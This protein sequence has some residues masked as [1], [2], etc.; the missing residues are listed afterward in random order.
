MRLWDPRAGDNS[1]TKLVGHTECVRS[2]LLSDDGRYMLTGSSDTT[3]KLWSVGEHRC[4]HTFNHHTSSVW[5][6]HS[7]HP[8]LERFYS[9]S[10][11][12]YLCAIDVEQVGDMSE[13]ECVVLGRE[14]EGV[15]PGDFESKTGDEAI[16]SITAMDDEYVWTATASSD[17]RRWRD[18]GR[19]VTRLDTDFDGASYGAITGTADEF[20]PLHPTASVS[21][22]AAFEP[23]GIIDAP[24]PLRNK[25][26]SVHEDLRRVDSA[27][28]RTIT[29]AATSPPGSPAS[30]L[31]ASVRDRLNPNRAARTLSG[32]SVTNSVMSES[33]VQGGDEFLHNG[34]PYDSLVCLGLPD[35]PYAFGFSGA[36]HSTASLGST[37]H[38]RARS[39]GSPEES[40]QATTT[41][42]TGDRGA[43]GE[44]AP[45]VAARREFEDRDV[46]ADARPLR[47]Q[48]DAVI[49]GS[50]GLI[51]SLV[52]ND[53][54]HVLTLDT[55]GEIAIWHL[56]RGECLGRFDKRDVAEALE[57]ERGTQ[58]VA[59]EIKMHPHEVLELVQR[60][61]EGKNSV[62]PWCQVD[63]KVGQITVHLEGDRVFAAEILAEEMG[64]D[65]ATLPE[66]SKA[67]N[68]GKTVLGN[69]FRGLIKAEELE[70]TSAV[71]SSPSSVPGSLPS[72]SRSPANAMP[73]SPRHRQRALSSASL[74]G[75]IAPSI[76]IAG[77]ATRAERAAVLPEGGAGGVFGQSA[78]A[79][80]GWLSLPAAM[81]SRTPGSF[82]ASSPANGPLSPQAGGVT[83]DYFSMRK[84]PEASPTRE[85]DK[86]ATTSAPAPSPG[87]AAPGGGLLGKKK[88][89]GFG[90]KKAAESTM[91][92]VVESKREAPPPDEGPK[93]SERD[94]SQ[95]LFLD[96]VR[97]RAFR[98][99]SSAECP[100]I[101][102]P[103]STTLI[104]SEQA[105]ADGAYIVTYRSQV[106]ST[107]RDMEPLEMNS[108]FW[109]LNYLFASI[110]P[111][112]RRPPKIP[113]ILL[114][115]GT[116]VGSGVGLKVQASRTA[117][118]RGV[119]EHLQNVLARENGTPNASANTRDRA[120]SDASA[121]SG[122]SGIDDVPK[123]APEDSIELLCGQHVAEADM[124]VAT[125][126]QCYWRGGVDMVLH[127]RVKP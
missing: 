122:V 5:A 77:L 45:R 93:M 20:A 73:M 108:P 38:H 47:D 57:L 50:P 104:I 106:S 62:L 70:V 82:T 60:R 98:P 111:E 87:A 115:V 18:V 101:P 32:T 61:V 51:R 36:A 4:L 110:T 68:V 88:F 120:V 69:L 56:I 63:T 41:D 113:L 97:N 92:T 112:E 22:A 44:V 118:V 83:S 7:N 119:M 126:K 65:E 54:M 1:V 59:A 79:T 24:S 91:T 10:R 67:L 71:S 85:A 66:D 99:P 21:L 94:R 72:V 84:I 30:A 64:I 48:P 103:P 2:I 89:M 102:A 29:F 16:R 125:L 81:A 17:V 9:G 13:G 86:P 39:I 28:S 78:P 46:A 37:S 123:R 80:S 6:L 58:D 26:L 52:L 49:A 96:T 124:K 75:G 35:S 90:K 53:R 105:H 55:T 8:N 117:R 76:N 100:S 19:R 3:V 43:G 31:P 34:I 15:R 42:R 11:D 107:E 116:T 74:G 27:D 127:Y 109:L 114:P 23:T 40:P 121:L 25:P 12:G 33:S 14:G 95:L